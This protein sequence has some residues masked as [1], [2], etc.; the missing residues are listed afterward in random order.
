[1]DGKEILAAVACVCLTVV[2][3]AALITHTDGAILSLVVAAI[4]G[5]GGYTLCA[6]RR[7]PGERCCEGGA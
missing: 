7:P 4:A 2:E 5:L 3:G 1:M 6:A